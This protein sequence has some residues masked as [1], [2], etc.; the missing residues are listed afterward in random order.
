MAGSMKP[1]Q[2]AEHPFKTIRKI[3]ASADGGACPGVLLMYGSEEYLVNWACS[4]LKESLVNPMTAALDCIRLSE[5][6]VRAS[7]I[8][9]AC[10]TLPFMSKKKLVIVDADP[11]FASSKDEEG[12]E[13]SKK[14]AE[15]LPDIP[16]TTLLALVCSRPNK[17][18]TLYKAAA[19]AGLVFDFT[20]LDGATLKSWMMKRLSAAGKKADPELLLRFAGACGYGEK[21]GNYSLYNL[22]NDLNKVIALSAGDEITR[23][24]LFAIYT[25]PA[26][27]NVFAMLDSAFSG[28][29]EAAY[30]ILADSVDLQQASKQVGVMLGFIGLICSQLEIMVEASERRA[31]S[32]DFALIA[33][34]MGTNEYR[35]KKALQ[36]ASKKSVPQ[37]RAALDA[38][39]QM[40]KDMKNGLMDPRLSLELFIA[41][42]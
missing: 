40:E 15:Y 33:K 14:L 4:F 27:T 30:R 3:M 9:A 18:R 23:Q 8:I 24:E 16:R 41:G 20:P 26:Q 1:A 19:K 32:Q 28:S 42:L 5:D 22:E 34:E 31:E 25:P 6:S 21:D 35:L 12:G 38:A 2:A 37:L 29:K 7:E 11:L 36:T 13:D 17:T 39:Y 10:E